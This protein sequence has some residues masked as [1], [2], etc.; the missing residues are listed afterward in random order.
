M[1]FNICERE[2]SFVNYSISLTYKVQ[3][4]DFGW[5]QSIQACNVGSSTG[6]SHVNDIIFSLWF[7]RVTI[8]VLDLNTD[9]SVR[10]ER[11]NG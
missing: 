7:G 8:H 4:L 3:Y 6:C 2:T 11:T 9:V 5:S 10:K 1:S